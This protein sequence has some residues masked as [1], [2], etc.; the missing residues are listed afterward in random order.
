MEFVSI[1][2]YPPTCKDSFDSTLN[3]SSI[4]IPQS[5]HFI[6]QS[7][8][9][10]VD[11]WLASRRTGWDFNTFRFRYKF[12]QNR[13][14]YVISSTC[15]S[16]KWTSQRTPLAKNGLTFHRS[17]NRIYFDKFCFLTSF[18]LIWHFRCLAK[19]P[20]RQHSFLVS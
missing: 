4:I 11:L 2:S 8:M 9:Y 16:C 15:E 13:T 14:F 7:M 12:L 5:N 3:E 17:L 10:C 18:Y 19:K 6:N 20:R 1:F